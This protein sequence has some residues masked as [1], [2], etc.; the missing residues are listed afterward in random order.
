MFT[1]MCHNLND[2]LACLCPNCKKSYKAQEGFKDHVNKKHG[3]Q[4]APKALSKEEAE[5]IVSS[6]STK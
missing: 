3:G 5:S 4:L 1:H 2:S 6:L